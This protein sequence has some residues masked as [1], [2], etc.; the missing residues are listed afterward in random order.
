MTDLLLFAIACG[1]IVI[2]VVLAKIHNRIIDAVNIYY[3]IQKAK[4]L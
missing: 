3:E 1:Q 2:I 4:E